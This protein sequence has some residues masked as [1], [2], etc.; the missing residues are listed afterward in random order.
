M[1]I[2]HAL[3][4][5]ISRVRKKEWV[6]GAYLR[7]PL[8]EKGYGPWAELYDEQGQKDIG[9]KVGSQKIL[10]THLMEDEG[11]EEYLGKPIKEEKDNYAKIYEN[12]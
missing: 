9:V 10:I 7:L 4:K 6:K 12:K 2:K 11:Y 5:R 1:K 3:E 8:F